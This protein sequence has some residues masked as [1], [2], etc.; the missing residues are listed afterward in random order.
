MIYPSKKY[1]KVYLYKGMECHHFIYRYSM[2]SSE[3]LSC[4]CYA[5]PYFVSFNFFRWLLLT[6]NPRS[7]RHEQDASADKT[8]K[9]CVWWSN[10]RRVFEIFGWCQGKAIEQSTWTQKMGELLVGGGNSNIFLFSPR[11][12]GKMNPIWQAYFSSG[13]VQPPT[14]ETISDLSWIHHGPQWGEGSW[15]TAQVT[16]MNIPDKLMEKKSPGEHTRVI[17]W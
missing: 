3:V 2:T 15:K 13:L 5:F 14:S 16:G 6:K 11:T 12:L 9:K 10:G 7:H 1:R 4:G 17:G 8:Q